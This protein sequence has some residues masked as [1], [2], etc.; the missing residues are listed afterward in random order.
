MAGL[1]TRAKIGTLNCDAQ[2]LT[3]LKD[4]LPQSGNPQSQTDR[5]D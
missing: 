5:P 2:R 3:E 1:G 4:F